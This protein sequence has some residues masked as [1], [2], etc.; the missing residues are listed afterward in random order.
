MGDQLAR[1]IGAVKYVEYSLKSGREYKILIDE[2][3]FAHFSKLKDQEHRERIKEEANEVRRERT[4][5]NV[6]M[7]EKFLDVLYYF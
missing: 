7:F 3:V 1:D 4:K 6:F 5:Q 2:I